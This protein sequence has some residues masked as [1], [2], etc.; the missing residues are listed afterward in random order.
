[1]IARSFHAET[2]ASDPGN[3]VFVQLDPGGTEQY[4][5]A[6]HLVPFLRPEDQI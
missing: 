1:M 4:T 5:R 2:D 3:R 6:A